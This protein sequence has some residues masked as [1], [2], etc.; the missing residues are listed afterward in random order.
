MSTHNT[1]VFE[2]WIRG[3]FKTINTELEGLYFEQEDKGNVA[4]IGD[5]LK[6]RLLDDGNRMIVKLLNEGN[7][8]EG[9]DSGFNVL[10]NV[11]FFMAACRRHGLTDPENET[12]SPL[13]QASALAMQ[14]GASLGVVPR[15]ASAHQETHNLAIDGEYK[16]FT[17][18]ADES[19]F[20]EYNTRGVFAFIRASE[21]LRH[22]LPLGVSHPISFDL[23]DTAKRALQHVVK[24][25][26]MLFNSLDIDRFFYSVRPYFKPHFVGKVNY[27]GANAGDFAGINVIDLLLGLC[28]ADDPY[29]SQILV[30]KFLYLRPDDQL[31]LRDCMRRKSLLD[32]FLEVR[33]SSQNRPWFQRNAKIF[34]EVCEM[35]G[36]IATQHHEMLVAKFIE[37]PSEAAGLNDS[38]SLTASG[39]PLSVLLKSLR[40]LCDLRNAADVSGIESRFEDLKLLQSSV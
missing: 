1:Q 29:Y 21:A 17:N 13:K 15:F 30:E 37:K 39:P 38:P 40:H 32:Q 3:E 12:Q 33:E 20:L 24:T 2:N 35:H 8:D 26:A 11:G 23:L 14:L 6:Q 27:R 10:G 7:T 16:T 9:F 36:K 31:V 4:G 25:N 34:L 18:L 19:L 22:C 28:K 5:P